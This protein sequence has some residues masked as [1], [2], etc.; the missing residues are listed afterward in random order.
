MVMAGAAFGADPADSD[1]GAR[2]ELEAAVEPIAARPGEPTDVPVGDHTAPSREAGAEPGPGSLPA[3]LARG[4]HG[5]RTSYRAARE[6]AVYAYCMRVCSLDA[7]DAAVVAAFMT[8]FEGL[9]REDG[10]AA[11]L[12]DMDD[13]LLRAARAEAAERAEAPRRPDALRRAFG[14]RL[15][16]SS[17]RA[18]CDVMPKL[19]AARAGDLLSPEE[20]EILHR[21][22]ARCRT[23]QAAETRAVRAER[24]FERRIAELRMAPAPR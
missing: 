6:P 4:D 18:V 13:A 12:T 5:A 3:L 23:C 2:R 14:S 19:L 16:R 24:A 10:K 8:M 15:R 21:H 11:D 17:G 7:V 22:L 20:A 1:P 9:R